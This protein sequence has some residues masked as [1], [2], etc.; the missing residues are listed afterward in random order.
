ML[1]KLIVKT[2]TGFMI[3]FIGQFAVFIGFQS[4]FFEWCDGN[5]GIVQGF[6]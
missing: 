4:D 6:P 5:W 2:K 3:G 1:P